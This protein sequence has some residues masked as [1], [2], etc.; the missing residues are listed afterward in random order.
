M[1]ERIS[2]NLETIGRFDAEFTK[3]SRHHAQVR[4]DILDVKAEVAQFRADVTQRLQAL[5]LRMDE[6]ENS[7][8]AGDSRIKDLQRENRGQY[9]DI[10]TAIQDGL[11]NSIAYRE[12]SER[13]ELLE[14]RSQL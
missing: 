2:G 12:L 11:Q 1:N 4:G 5:L 7:I 8:D 6:V 13:V 9:N 3:L 14:R 10:L